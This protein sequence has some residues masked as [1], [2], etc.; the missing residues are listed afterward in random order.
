MKTKDRLRK[1][2]KSGN[3][4]ENKGSYALKAGMLLKRKGLGGRKDS[5]WWIVNN[6]L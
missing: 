6:E 5:E 2:E 1:A 4:I 3:V